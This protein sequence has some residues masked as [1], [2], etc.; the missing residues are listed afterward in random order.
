MLKRC[1]PSTDDRGAI[2]IHAALG[3]LALAAFLTFVADYGLMWTARRQA[4][5]SADAGAIAG[6]TG[7]G[8]DDPTDYSDTGLAKQNAYLATQTNLVW[9]RVP[10]VDISTNVTFPLVPT[11][12]C[13]PDG[14]G[15][16]QCVRVEVFRTAESANPLP[17]LFG[18]ILGI[19]SQDTRASAMAVV[20]AANQSKCLKPW[21]V[22]DKWAEADGSWDPT[23]TF[24]PASGDDYRYQGE[25]GPQ[26]PGT[27]FKAPPGTP[28]DFGQ[29]LILKVGNPQDTINPGW[30]QA[31]DLS[32]APDSTCTNSGAACY[33]DAI[34]SCAGGTWKIGDMVPI[35]TGDM[36]GPTDQ[37][38]YRSP[39]A[40]LVDLDPTA[41]WDPVNKQIINSCA[42]P[43]NYTCPQPGYRESPRIVAI[44]VFDLELYL[45][46]GGPGQGTVKIVNILGFFVDRADR[47]EVT[48]YLINKKGTYTPGGS[49]IA[50]PASFL[51]QVLLIR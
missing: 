23:D 47:G 39:G 8:Y 2:L 16:S 15:L 22:A 32:S 51:K 43:S 50:G 24:D 14:D 44:P 49:S 35:E 33:R 4:Q 11:A 42:N 21:G 27:G 41:D 6:A 36:V 34:F 30:F 17:M 1:L 46:T 45:A 12:D 37:A 20:A 19:S 13:D 18:H 26:D 48:G 7:L 31:L 29:E 9:G 3:V 40:N 25:Q 10:Y 28:N 5:N 38:V